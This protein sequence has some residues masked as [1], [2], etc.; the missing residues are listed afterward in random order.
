MLHFSLPNP[1]SLEINYVETKEKQIHLGCFVC[2]EVLHALFRFSE[3]DKKELQYLLACRYQA[4]KEAWSRQLQELHTLLA[5]AKD[6]ERKIN[7]R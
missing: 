4:A 6:R 3:L 1:F 5:E 7:Q 2:L